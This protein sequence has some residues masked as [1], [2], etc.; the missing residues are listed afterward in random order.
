MSQLQMPSGLKLC[1]V[2]GIYSDNCAKH[3][4]AIHL[5]KCWCFKNQTCWYIW[6]QS[7]LNWRVT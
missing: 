7:S 3:V 4:N 1:D 2:I 5:E 6:T